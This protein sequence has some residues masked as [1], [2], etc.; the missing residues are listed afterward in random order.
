LVRRTTSNK[1]KA[2]NA[3]T[4]SNIMKTETQLTPAPALEP[5]TVP[6]P[7][8]VYGWLD[9][10]IKQAFDGVSLRGDPK[11]VLLLEVTQGASMGKKI[12]A[13][14]PQADW[15]KALDLNNSLKKALNI[16]TSDPLFDFPQLIGKKVSILV[17]PWEVNGATLESV[18]DFKPAA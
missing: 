5:A 9:A 2:V 16:A 13:H 14:I 17:A 4:I 10:E 7:A 8:P 11:I 15:G 12:K 6:A 3:V 1:I 18:T